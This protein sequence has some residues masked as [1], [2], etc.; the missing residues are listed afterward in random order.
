[1]GQQNIISELEKLIKISE[2]LNWQLAVFSVSKLAQLPENKAHF[3]SIRELQAKEVLDKAENCILQTESLQRL[4]DEYEYH[5]IDFDD[6]LAPLRSKWA[7]IIAYELLDNDLSPAELTQKFKEYK[8]HKIYVEDVYK[9]LIKQEEEAEDK[10][11]FNLLKKPQKK[12]NYLP[13]DLAPV[14]KFIESIGWDETAATMIIMSAVAGILE[15][16][17]SVSIPEK[18]WK[19]RCLSMFTAL[20]CRSGKMKT[21]LMG[22]LVFD[23]I[24]S[25][26]EDEWKCYQEELEQ[27]EKENKDKKP[28][29]QAPK[30]VEPPKRIMGDLTKEALSRVFQMNEGNGVLVAK[31]ELSGFFKGLNQYKRGK[32]DDTE[33]YCELWNG[34]VFPPERVGEKNISNGI[35]R[36]QSGILG[37]IQPKILQSLFGNETIGNGFFARFSWYLRDTAEKFTPTFPDIED[38]SKVATVSISKFMRGFYQKIMKLTATDF[39]FSS[40]AKKYIKHQINKIDERA[41]QAYRNGKDIEEEFLLKFRGKL[42]RYC[43]L[44]Q[45]IHYPDNPSLKINK[46]IC[47]IAFNLLAEELFFVKKMISLNVSNSQETLPDRW[48]KILDKAAQLDV[49]KGRDIQRQYG[50]KAEIVRQDFIDMAKKGLGFTVGKGT[51]LGFTIN[52]STIDN[53]HF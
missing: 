11:I 29:E 43:A 7:G 36:C 22:E 33:F 38:E 44:L 1:M 9:V 8:A 16:G 24:I 2:S 21:P 52:S 41:D 4:R 25:L 39:T 51:R 45:I 18:N 27:W 13:N 47:Q 48:I 31:D 42:L 50:H 37:G 28:S 23:P 17:F 53:N 46:T 12:N 5:P 32:G 40:P 14:Q 34:R 15:Q 35:F 6:L 10:E 49:V 30:P 26:V 3:K 19:E 20:V